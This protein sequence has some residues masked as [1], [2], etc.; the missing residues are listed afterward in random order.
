MYITHAQ[1]I[2]QSNNTYTALPNSHLG[3]VCKISMNCI[4]CIVSSGRITS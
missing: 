4:S 3:T 2:T 1:Y